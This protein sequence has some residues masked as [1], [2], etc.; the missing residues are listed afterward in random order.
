MPP[1]YACSAK[2]Q[3]IGQYRDLAMLHGGQ[4]G[5]AHCEVLKNHKL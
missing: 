2:I 3:C 5:R 1:T 4:C